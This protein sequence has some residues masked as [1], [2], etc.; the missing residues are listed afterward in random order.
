M[1]SDLTNTP[2][3]ANGVLL[4]D[5]PPGMSS[6]HAL[7][8]AKWLL[9]TK[10][11][12][13]TGSLDPVATGLLPLCFGESTKVAGYF[14]S[15]DKRYETTI[16]L[17]V[18][19]D[20][21]DRSGKVTCEKEVN[22][23]KRKIRKV[24]NTFVGEQMQV[25]PMFS[26]VKVKGKRLYKYARQG[27]E[28]PRNPRPVSI[29]EIQLLRL[30]KDHAKIELSCSSG[31]YVRV[32]AHEVGEKLDCGA[33]VDSLRRLAVGH[34]SIDDSVTLDELEKLPT[35]SERRE[36]LIPGDQA[37]RHLPEVELSADAAYYLCRGQSVR[38]ND[39][40]SE[41]V[42]RLYEK[43]AGFLGLGTS[44]GDGR[45]APKRLFHT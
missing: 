25:P 40:P 35:V 10:K 29:Y 41:G 8:K 6:N 26:A 21:G 5:K 14:L 17:G 28:L 33:H 19:T 36:L 18:S 27:I 43:S 1:H 31:F 23:T 2:I 11:A 15:A 7:G 3:N 16:K 39:L 13:H 4:L 45:V 37:L 32:L 42:V 30:D 22:V 12:G 24:L 38:A 34:L 20:S 9:E 44:L